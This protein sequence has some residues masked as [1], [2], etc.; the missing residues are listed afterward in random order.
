[1]RCPSNEDHAETTR[2]I[3]ATFFLPSEQTQFNKDKK[4]VF[5]KLMDAIRWEEL[6]R[7]INEEKI[8]FPAGTRRRIADDW[9][10]FFQ[11]NVRSDYVTAMAALPTATEL[12]EGRA[13]MEKCKL[14]GNIEQLRT[15]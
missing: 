2:K 4:I 11:G 7:R 1:M 5:K 15:R 6:P 12:Q 10:D 3:A 14:R 8:V 13:A 9:D